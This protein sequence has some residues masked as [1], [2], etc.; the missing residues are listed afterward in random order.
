MPNIK[1]SYLYRDSGNY[2]N[3]SHV[4]FDN[5]YNIDLK[6]LELL[7]KSRL[8]DGSWFY[9]ER[10]QLPDLHFNDWNNTLDHTFHEFESIA[11]T[12]EAANHSLSLKLF[13]QLIK[14]SATI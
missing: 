10:W 14:C 4:V 9:A 5:P 3:Y 7:I 1:F 6:C 13:I 11:Y 2:K 12:S 8:I